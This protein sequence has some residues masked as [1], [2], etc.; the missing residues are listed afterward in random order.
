MGKGKGCEEQ[1]RI[2]GEG[3]ELNL[4]NGKAHL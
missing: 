3:E 4:K 2:Q 1:G